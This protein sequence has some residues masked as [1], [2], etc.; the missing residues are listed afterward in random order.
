MVRGFCGDGRGLYWPLPCERLIAALMA[1]R[2]GA[3]VLVRVVLVCVVLAV[4]VFVLLRFEHRTAPVSTPAPL[5]I[6]R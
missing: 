3:K 2:L 6:Q 4:V 5:Q 1:W